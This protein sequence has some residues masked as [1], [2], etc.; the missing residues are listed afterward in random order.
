MGNFSWFCGSNPTKTFDELQ[1]EFAQ[2]LDPKDPGSVVYWDDTNDS[3]VMLVGRGEMSIWDPETKKIIAMKAVP[4]GFRWSGPLFG[5][6]FPDQE[7]AGM[8]VLFI[9]SRRGGDARLTPET[10]DEA[11]KMWREQR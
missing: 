10:Y 9:G 7:V 8:S 6:L 5:I 1:R 4:N 11:V 2:S 3:C